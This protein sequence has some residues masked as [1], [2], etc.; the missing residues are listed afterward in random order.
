[1]NVHQ[2]VS[3]IISEGEKIEIPSAFIGYDDAME[4]KDRFTNLK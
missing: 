2:S 1:M 3:F 4:L